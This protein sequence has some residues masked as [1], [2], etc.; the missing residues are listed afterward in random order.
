MGQPR[1][2]ADR[3]V[4]PANLQEQLDILDMFPDRADRIQTLIEVADQYRAIPESE[5]PKPYPEERRVPGCETEVFIFDAPKDHD[6]PCLVAVQNP[7]G[8]SA[9]ALAVMLSKGMK[10]ASLGEL[11]ALSGELVYKI[12]GRE[13]S[14]G[15]SMGL[16]NTLEM[17]KRAAIKKLL[18]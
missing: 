7:Q 11:E 16:T 15:K 18:G 10:G 12:F 6:W 9:M 4:I 8:I 14:M 3:E 1:W 17:M 13:L 2:S 5:I